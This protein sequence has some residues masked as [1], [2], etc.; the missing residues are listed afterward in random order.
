M[1][2]GDT[3][4]RVP[5]MA[6]GPGGRQMVIAVENTLELW[7]LSSGEHVRTLQ[8]HAGPVLAARF[9]PDGSRLASSDSRAVRLWA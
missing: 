1:G 8:G 6:F 4:L 5:A 3:G 9:S 7:D 2:A